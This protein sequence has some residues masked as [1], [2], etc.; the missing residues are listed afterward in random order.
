MNAQ[1]IADWM[2]AYLARLLKVGPEHIDPALAF[3][4]YGIDSKSAA[5]FI[6]D[7]SQML[8]DDLDL[9]I[10]Y[11]HPSIEEL[12]AYLADRKR[13]GIHGRATPA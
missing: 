8:N 5:A 10:F 1:Q 3:D 2:S 4:N 9:S 13:E 6:G 12:S 11:D 7:L